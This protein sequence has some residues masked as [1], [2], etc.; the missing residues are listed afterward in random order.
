MIP[1]QVITVAIA[2]AHAAAYFGAPSSATVRRRHCGQCL[3]AVKTSY[4]RAASTILNGVSVARRNR[5]KPPFVTISR[6]FASP[7]CAPRPARLPGLAR[8]AHTSWS[9][10]S[11]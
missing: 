11:I 8:L 2:P 9:R 6:S 5:V 4:G 7:A 1:A 10:H 3:I